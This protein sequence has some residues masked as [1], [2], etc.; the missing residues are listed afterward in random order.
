VT[1]DET[2]KLAR[3]QGVKI[4]LSEAGDEVDLEA[5]AEPPQALL[6]ALKAAKWDIISELRRREMARRRHLI[7]KWVNDH[8]T[9]SPP[10]VCRYC[11]EGARE[12]DVFV[13]LYCGADSGDV[14]ASC[15]SAWRQA[16]EAKACVALGF[17]PLI[18]P[19]DR[20]RALLRDIEKARPPD[21]ADAQWDAAMRGLRTFLAAGHGD[22]AERLGWPK[23]GLYNVPKLWSQIH[24][25]G[26]AL[27]VGDRQVTEITAETIRIRTASGAVLSFY[28]RPRAGKVIDISG[29][30]A[31]RIAMRAS[32]TVT[33]AEPPAPPDYAAVYHAR[34]KLFGDDALTAEVPLRCFDYVVALCRQHSGCDI[35]TARTRAAL[36]KESS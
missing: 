35:D 2:L 33:R 23:D 25:C 21:A 4:S 17:A 8:F 31:V 5:E 30:L 11:G 9:P 3:S 16:E 19:L 15:E 27:L 36:A 6:S 26:A 18:D 12:G 29:R 28:R 20:H 7:V 13:H 22:E 24:L 10:D 1:I 14:H 34:L 32:A